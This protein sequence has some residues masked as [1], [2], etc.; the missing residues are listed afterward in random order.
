MDFLVRKDDLNITQISPSKGQDEFVLNAGQVLLKVDSFAFTANNVTYGHFG[1]AMAYWS[2][3][4]APEGLGRVPVWGFANVAASTIGDIKVGERIFGYLPISSH[5][6]IEPNRLN[7][8][9]FTDASKHRRNLPAVYNVYRRWVNDPN[10]DLKREPELAIFLPLYSTAFLLD[11]HMSSE[12]FWGADTIVLSSASSKTAYA[13][14]TLLHERKTTRVVGVTSEEHF[15]FTSGIGC[16]DQV[17][18]YAQIGALEAGSKTVYVDMSGSGKIRSEIHKLLGDKLVQDVMIGAT[19][20]SEAGDDSNLDGI[21]PVFFFAPTQAAKRSHDWGADV[22]NQR[23][24]ESLKDFI[25][26]ATEP[27]NPVLTVVRDRGMQAVDRIYHE[28]LSGHSSPG[29]GY[30]LSL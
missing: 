1:D 9:G 27:N 8:L 6:I 13:T 18:T 4:P 21:K 30:V 28:V 17:L 12:S 7:P 16:Y 24:A 10:Y 29:I 14:A 22:L 19:H 5:L 20:F 2:F 25:K 15:A 3:F 11:D 26:K 23:V